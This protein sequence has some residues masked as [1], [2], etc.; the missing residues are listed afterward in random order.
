M[1][2]LSNVIHST[3]A[4]R[5]PKFLQLSRD[6]MSIAL[7]QS[8]PMTACLAALIFFGGYDHHCWLA[9]FGHGLR[10]VFDRHSLKIMFKPG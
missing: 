5:S 1:L 6:C 10:T 9:M 7:S 3:A 2:R 4:F 8:Q